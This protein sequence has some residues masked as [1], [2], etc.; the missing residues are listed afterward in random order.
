MYKAI[1]DIGEYRVGDIVPDAQAK[2]WLEAYAVPQVEKV[3]EVIDM[4][5]VEDQ[6]PKKSSVETILEDYLAR[7]QSVVKKNI[8]EDDLNKYQ[9]ETLLKIEM[10]DRRRPLI[11]NT[12]KGRLRYL[13][14]DEDSDEN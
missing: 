14:Q 10:A 8:T 11:I 3:D 6:T 12:I 1:K 13:S 7:S 2:L 4:K 9:L 5:K